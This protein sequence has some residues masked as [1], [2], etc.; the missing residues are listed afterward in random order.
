MTDQPRSRFFLWVLLGGGAFFLFLL[1]VFALVYFTA[2]WQQKNSFAGGFGDKIAVVDLE[3]VILSPKDVV[4]DLRK[5]ADDSSVKAI[6]IHVNSPGGGAA[7]S[8][9]IYREVLRIRDVK[10]KRIVA[11]IETVGAS[12][13]YYVLSATNKIFA[14]NASIVGSIGVIAEWYNYEELLK[15]AKLRAI[16]LK[17]GEFKDTG[18]PVREMTPAERAYMQ[19]MIDNMHAQFIGSVAA[20]RHMKVEEIQPLADGKVW[21]GE[22]AM[23]LKLIDQIGDFRA[24]VEDTAK[25][26]GI[27]GEP[28][29]VRPEKERKGLLDLLFGDASEYFPDPAT[30]TQSN[31]GFY[32]LWK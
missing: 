27:K 29:I 23:P 17:A 28:T 18:S 11:S 26:V 22:Q 24:A 8:E 2:R 9:E 6:I 13:A 25:S 31:A 14:D 21:T 20:G 10:K 4:E 30:L 3:G 32:Y 7:A 19:G 12:G 5:F 1:A 15:W 16:V